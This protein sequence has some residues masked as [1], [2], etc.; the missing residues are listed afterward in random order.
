MSKRLYEL[1][2]NALKF[3]PKIDFKNITFKAMC[4]NR[5]KK[6]VFVELTEFNSDIFTI[7]SAILPD[8]L[9]VLA[10]FNK[11]NQLFTI[12]NQDLLFVNLSLKEVYF[13]GKEMHDLD[14]LYEGDFRRKDSFFYL[15]T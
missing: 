13:Y 15:I 3:L 5:N 12:E 14:W 11:K 7:H 9:F 4:I 1:S 2:L 6:I 10:I 8:D